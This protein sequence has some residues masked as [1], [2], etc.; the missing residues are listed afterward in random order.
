MPASGSR[1]E[2]DNARPGPRQSGDFKL[3]IPRVPLFLFFGN[4]NSREL[5]CLWVH[6]TDRRETDSPQRENGSFIGL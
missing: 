1:P 3:K 5:S 6:A 2:L 4:N